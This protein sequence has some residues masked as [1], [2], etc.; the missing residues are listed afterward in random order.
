M[1]RQK[2]EVD[3][4]AEL[5]RLEAARLKLVEEDLEKKLYL[6][7]IH[8]FPWYPWAKEFYDSENKENFLCA[9][10]QISKSSTL[11][12]KFIDWATD[13]GAWAKRWPSLLQ[14]QTPNQ[15][16]YFYPT[17][18]VW[19]TEFETKWEPL[20]LPR[21]KYKEHPVYGWKAYFAK[22]LIKKIE[23]NSGVTIYCKVYSQKP[24]DLQTGTVY[25]VGCDEELP[26]ELF[27]E[28]QARLNATDGY[29]NMVFTATLGQLYWEQT[30]EP[31]SAAEE[32]HVGAWKRQVSLYDSQVYTDG[33]PS[34]WNLEKI[35][36]IEAKCPS[37][38]ERLRRVM[39]KF[40]KTSG[41]RLE[42]FQYDRNVCEAHP[43]PKG[44]LTY[45]GIDPGSGGAS[46][47]PAAIAVVSVSPDCRVGRVIRSW[48]GDGIVTSSEDIVR[49]YKKL[50]QG[51]AIR[52]TAY[53]YQAKDFFIV[54]S[55]MGL[56]LTPAN[57][58][59]ESGFDIYNTLLKTG[60]LKIQEGV[61]DNDKL[62]SE[63]HT[64]S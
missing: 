11:I 50:V 6:P 7:H 56:S 37:E 45:A 16:W 44:W 35:K 31:K 12:R 34:P 36:R 27:P 1:S 2:K 5:L 28:I 20:F 18:D 29:F 4:Q 32:R 60:M 54:G 8:S 38:A 14:G 17:Y 25:M 61:F 51:L 15:F 23:F 19:Q 41:L 55:R 10:N 62:I 49:E 24:K 33:T 22:G 39:G 59:R 53:D 57:K 13:Q 63:V 30:I 47:H 21:G 64:L 42:G 43:L 52:A 3:T 48:R 40:V 9:A 26:I 46:G 58:K